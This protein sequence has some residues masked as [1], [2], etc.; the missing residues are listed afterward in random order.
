MGVNFSQNLNALGE[1]KFEFSAKMFWNLNGP[2]GQSFGPTF[3]NFAK[4]HNFENAEMM[5][6]AILK[7]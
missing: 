1:F 4:M 5:I 6:L 2:E 7:I 3:S